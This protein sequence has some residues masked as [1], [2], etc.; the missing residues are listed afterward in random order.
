M[1]LSYVNQ[2]VYAGGGGK[3]YSAALSE[4]GEGGGSNGSLSS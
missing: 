2:G 3:L 1:E 4:F